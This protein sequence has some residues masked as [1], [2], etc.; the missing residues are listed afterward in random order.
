M[1]PGF[2]MVL[3][4]FGGRLG[5]CVISGGWFVVDILLTLLK[6]HIVS[7]SIII[8]LFRPFSIKAISIHPTYPTFGHFEIV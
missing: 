3:Y 6:R 4:G 5:G 7:I 8:N 2:S 1:G